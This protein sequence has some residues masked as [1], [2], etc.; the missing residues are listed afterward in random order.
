MLRPRLHLFHDAYKQTK[1]IYDTV[2]NHSDCLRTLKKHKRNSPW[3]HGLS[4]QMPVIFNDCVKHGFDFDYLLN[5]IN[6]VLFML[7]M[8][9]GRNIISAVNM[10]WTSTDRY[11]NSCLGIII[12][13]SK[14]L[15]QTLLQTNYIEI[16]P[17][18]FSLGALGSLISKS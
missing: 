3:A 10:K 1:Y 5:K 12:I 18:F 7:Q 13:Y 4:L 9:A 15:K 16:I 2:T 14:L 11:L 6:V 17:T 8:E